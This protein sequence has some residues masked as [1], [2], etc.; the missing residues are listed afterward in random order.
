MTVQTI[1]SRDNPL[2]KQVCALADS[3]R[4]REE[5]GAF[6]CEGPVMLAEALRSGAHILRV[7][8]LPELLPDL[9]SLTCPVHPVSV[10][11]L[12][13]ISDVPSP[14]GMV[15]LCALPPPPPLSGTR[16]LALDELRDPG[17]LGTILRTADAFGADGVAL[18]GDC[19]DP[20][21]PKVV[22]ATMGS[23]FRI[24]LWHCDMET[25][26]R[27]IH[28]PLYAAVLDSNSQPVAALSLSRACIVVGNEAHGISPAVRALC[29]GAV[30]IPIRGAESLNAAVAAA[31]FLYEM[32]RGRTAMSVGTN[33]A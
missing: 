17:N 25:L 3:R 10:P 9:P 15:F 28:V 12:K 14:Q 31:I 1:T 8:C 30:N 26:K 21:S 22:R 24:P 27:A 4:A 29:D 7:F 16:L 2:V 23:L 20:F 19:A 33:E 13:K 6:V 11:V 32:S 18:L 5:A